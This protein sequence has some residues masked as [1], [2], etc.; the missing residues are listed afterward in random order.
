MYKSTADMIDCVRK[1]YHSAINFC[2]FKPHQPEHELLI[3][4]ESFTRFSIESLP[5]LIRLLEFSS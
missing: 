2:I 4:I 3:F 5:D 1:Q